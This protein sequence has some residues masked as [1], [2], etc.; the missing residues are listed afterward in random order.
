MR[1]RDAS[2]RESTTQSA[3]LLLEFF[4]RL[5]NIKLSTNLAFL[6]A[7]TFQIS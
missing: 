2:I 4:K 5:Q 3:F 6:C 1:A 7:G